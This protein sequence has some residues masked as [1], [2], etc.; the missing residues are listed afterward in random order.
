[1]NFSQI[2]TKFVV[3]KETVKNFTLLI[4]NMM[5]FIFTKNNIQWDK[6]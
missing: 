4:V 3:R 5:D 1:M 2:F 6:R